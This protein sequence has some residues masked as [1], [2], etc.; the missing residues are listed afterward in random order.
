MIPDDLRSQMI[1]NHRRW[2]QT[3]PDHQPRWSQMINPDDPR[4]STQMINPDDPRSSQMISD[5][6]RWS[7]MIPDDPRWSQ[8]TPNDPRWSEMIRDK[9]ISDNLSPGWSQVIS[10]ERISDDFRPT[11]F[12]MIHMLFG[13]LRLSHFFSL[14]PTVQISYPSA[15]GLISTSICILTELFVPGSICFLLWC[16]YYLTKPTPQYLRFDALFVFS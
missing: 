5:D 10:E 3:I 7:Q 1:P 2:F 4:W 8:V 9:M 14:P 12:Q 11:W 13:V 6:L 15:V 16:I